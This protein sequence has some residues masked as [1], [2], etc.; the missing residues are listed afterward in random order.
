MLHLEVRESCLEALAIRASCK[1]SYLERTVVLHPEGTHHGIFL[2]IE[3]VK[4]LNGI[5][6]ANGFNPNVRDRFLQ[7]D[8]AP[9]GGVMSD[10]GR[11]IVLAFDKLNAELYP[12]LMIL[13]NHH[14]RMIE[15]HLVVA[16]DLDLC[17]E[18][19]AVC[20]IEEG[21]VVNGESVVSDTPVVGL[22]GNVHFECTAL[23]G[24]RL[25]LLRLLSPLAESLHLLLAKHDLRC[26]WA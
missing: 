3:A 17:F 24:V 15:T 21:A 1:R 10:N 6:T 12:I 13:T 9:V 19:T 11:D 22:T 23:D 14:T 26:E 5:E 16:A 8:D 25:R 18:L 2:I 7:L 4:N 20:S